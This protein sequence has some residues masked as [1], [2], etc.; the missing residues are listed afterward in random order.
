MTNPNIER[1]KVED[2]CVE[3][4]QAAIRHVMAL[5]MA[6]GRQHPISSFAE[7]KAADEIERLQAQVAA[8][9]KRAEELQRERDEARATTLRACQSY[10]DQVAEIAAERDSARSTLVRVKAENGALRLALE[11]MTEEK[12]DYMLINNLGDPETQYTVKLARSALSPHP[13][14]ETQ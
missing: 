4:R 5:E 8:S 14:R 11:H 13:E 2:L 1:D 6:T 10:S 12:C 7:G 3:L 9:E